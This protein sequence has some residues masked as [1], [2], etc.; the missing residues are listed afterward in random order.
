MTDSHERN[1]ACE[2]VKNIYSSCL[3]IF[4][5][6]IVMGLI[7]TEQTKL[8][9]DVHPALAFFVLWGLVIWLGMVEG[10]QASLVGLAPI[11]FDLYKDSHPI[12][13]ISTKVC[14]V[15]DNL[16]RYLM[17]RQFMVIFI[18]FCINMAGA[19]LKDSELWG[20]PKWI[21]DIFLVTGFAMILLTAM[22]GQLATQVNASHCMLDYINSYFGVFTFYTA[23]AIE[24]S[25]LMHVSYFIQ[26]VVGYAAGKP[27]E[28]NEPPKTGLQLAFFWLRVVVSAASLCFCLAVTLEAL[29]NGQTTMWE[30][31]PNAVAV[32][33][34]FL[35]MSVVGLLE[36]MQIA[37]FAVAKLKKSERGSAPFAMRTCELLFR[38]S[39][40]NLPGFMIGRQLCVV[41]CFFIIARVTSLDV[42]VGV[43]KNVFGVSDAAQ[44]FFNTGL[45]GAVITTI[46]GSISWQLVASAFPLAFLSNPLVYVFLRICLFLEA[47]GICSGAWVLAA[48][49]KKIAGFQRDEVYIGTAEERAAKNMEDHDENQHVEHG[50]RKLPGFTDCPEALVK[51]MNQDPSVK[52]FVESISE[53]AD[54]VEENV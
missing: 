11:N 1:P 8:S 40:H 36:G 34:F 6:V 10:G 12:T 52:S 45:L 44:E 4:S 49:H 31:V 3:L 22:I 24:F 41:S 18:A 29:F 30:G 53:G 39:G 48:I 7:F 38:G 47:T 50:L 32:I 23:M 42:N 37:F 17:G 28:S 21:I 35:L 5:I 46:L 26:M 33:L 25:G 15:G 14:H 43:D 13:Y 19:P 27:I 54:K 9:N 2:M 16:D 51:L 20:L